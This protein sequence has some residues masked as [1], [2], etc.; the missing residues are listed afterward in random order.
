MKKR[1]ED[2][3]AL[4]FILCII[5]FYIL[6]YFIASRTHVLLLVYILLS[7]SIQRGA[8]VKRALSQIHCSRV[9]NC[10]VIIPHKKTK[11]TID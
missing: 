7:Q 8:I 3:D 2:G 10:C 11:Q 5:L 4:F 9:N 6:F 1:S